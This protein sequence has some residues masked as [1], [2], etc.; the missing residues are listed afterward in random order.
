MKHY[1]SYM[2]RI[3]APA[4]LRQRVLEAAVKHRKHHRE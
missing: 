3:T 2:D 1:R 4:G